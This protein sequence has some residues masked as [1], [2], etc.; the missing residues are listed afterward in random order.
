MIFTSG[1][2]EERCQGTNRVAARYH[3]LATGLMK[4]TWI[5]ILYAFG[6]L[7]GVYILGITANASII[8]LA[9]QIPTVGITTAVLRDNKRLRWRV[10]LVWTITAMFVWGYSQSSPT[11]TSQGSSNEVAA[12][13]LFALIGLWF[14]RGVNGSINEFKNNRQSPLAVSIGNTLSAWGATLQVAF[15]SLILIKAA[16]IP[17]L[18]STIVGVPL[19]TLLAAITLTSPVSWFPLGL[20]LIGLTLFAA[21]R[22]K[23]DPYLP[24]GYADVLPLKL[25]PLINELFSALRLPTWLC[26]VIFGFVA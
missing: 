19:M 18:K 20:L 2:T 13:S 12:C 25:P 9:V 21:V 24:K 4:H 22:F 16:L 10:P 15:L 11:A 14:V 8:F 26:T 3:D 17:F 6:C 7:I 23:D 5:A 1:A